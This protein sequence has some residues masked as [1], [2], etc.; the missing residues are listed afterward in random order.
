MSTGAIIKLSILVRHDLLFLKL[1]M[2]GC[3]LVKLRL[4]LRCKI[5]VLLSLHVD[6]L[7]F[8]DLSLKQVKSLI[9][10]DCHSINFPPKSA[11]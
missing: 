9:F 4:E 6:V 10:L 2:S 5:S 8:C 3:T 1:C 11:L 7:E